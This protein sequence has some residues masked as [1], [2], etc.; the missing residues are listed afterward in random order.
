MKADAEQQ[1]SAGLPRVLP[2]AMRIFAAYSA[3]Y[4]RKSFHSV[5]ISA[6]GLPPP[7]A[8]RPVVI[9]LNHAAW[10]DPLVCVRLAREFFPDRASFAP[11]DAAML[12]RY[13]FFR[14]LGFFGVEARQ[15]RG[16][17]TFL[18]TTHAILAT[19]R[20][21]VW[22]T[23]QGRFMDVR[24]RPLRLENGLGALA[25]REPQAA[26]VPLAIEYAFWTEPRPEILVSFGA[27]ILPQGDPDRS[28]FAWTCAFTRALEET[29]DELAA[30]SLR[31]DA[32]EWRTLQ[33]GASGVSGI[34]DAWRW[35]KTWL[36]GDTFTPEHR[37]EP[38]A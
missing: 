38:A 23:P 7:C 21:A 18:R 35:L 34:Y 4:L 24:E 33:T 1:S 11:I 30:R 14:H 20:H 36:R 12:E 29:Q 19:S 27:P 26:F 13:A 16:A 5:R 15:P 3:R 22:L 31:R 2:G 8:D 32:A 37:P 6:S 17:L 25:V 28:A 10:W 9:Y